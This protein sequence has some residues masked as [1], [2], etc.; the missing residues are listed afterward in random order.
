MTA[1]AAIDRDREARGWQAVDDAG[2]AIRRIRA[3]TPLRLASWVRTVAA[4]DPARIAA[5]VI[6]LA[7]A[8][9]PGLDLE[10]ALAAW[11]DQMPAAHVTDVTA[12]TRA[13]S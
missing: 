13:T 2:S 5:L 6:T 10:A 1:I 3:G 8:I 4:E 11:V 12:Q 7:A 9:P